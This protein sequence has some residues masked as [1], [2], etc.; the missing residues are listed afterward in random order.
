[1]PESAIG[2]LGVEGGSRR[3]D[4]PTLTLFTCVSLTPSFSSNCLLNTYV[5]G[6]VLGAGSRALDNTETVSVIRGLRI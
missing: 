6:I 4:I 3:S 2:L 5:V 1:M